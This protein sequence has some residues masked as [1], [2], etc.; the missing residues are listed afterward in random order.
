[1]CGVA[2]QLGEDLA[3]EDIVWNYQSSHLDRKKGSHNIMI[4]ICNLYM[5]TMECFGNNYFSPR[6]KN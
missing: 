3:R 6:S 4:V 1:M 2:K 5:F